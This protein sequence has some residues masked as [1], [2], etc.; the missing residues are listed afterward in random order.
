MAGMDKAEAMAFVSRM[1]DAAS[2]GAAIWGDPLLVKRFLS[3]CSRTGS[4]ET[5]RGYRREIRDFM[6]WRDLHHPHLLLREMTAPFC[7]D[8][9]DELRRE[10]EAERLKP[11]TFN[12]RIAAVSSL[13]RWASEPS[14]SAVT[15][16]PRNPIPL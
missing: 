2:A 10:V 4:E 7:Q 5:I 16:V 1:F 14:R 15:G 11:R 8:F 12:R 9:V 6:R 3:Q 13:F